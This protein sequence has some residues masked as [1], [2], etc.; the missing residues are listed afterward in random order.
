MFHSGSLLTAPNH[1]PTHKPQKIGCPK[2]IIVEEHPWKSPFNRST[3]IQGQRMD[4]KHEKMRKAVLPA[5]CCGV[6]V[7][8]SIHLHTHLTSH[9][10]CLTSPHTTPSTRIGRSNTHIHPPNNQEFHIAFPEH[11]RPYIQVLGFPGLMLPRRTVL[12]CTVPYIPPIPYSPI[13]NR[14]SVRD[15]FRDSHS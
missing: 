13:I 7:S 15:C 9:S 4:H 2:R 5:C 14:H 10:P 12:Y 1:A 6:T 3:N 11:R 8:P